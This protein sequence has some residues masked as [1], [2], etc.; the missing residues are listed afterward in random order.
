MS[1]KLFLGGRYFENRLV[2]GIS[3]TGRGV[4]HSPGVLAAA[5]R[6]SG[7]EILNV[8]IRRADLLGPAEQALE[9][10]IEWDRYTLLPNTMGATTAGEAIRTAHLARD[11]TQGDWVK[12][13]ISSDNRYFFPDPVAILEA[14]R[15]LIADGFR[16]MP[17]IQ[18]D[19]ILAQRLEDLGCAA[20]L[21]M[22][23]PIGS[24]QGFRTADNVRIILEKVRIPVLVAAGLAL[25]S[26]AAAALEAG[27]GGVVVNM[28][29]CQA[30][31]P[32][33]MALAFKAGIEAGRHAYLAGPI[34]KLGHAETGLSSQAARDAGDRGDA[35]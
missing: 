26:E 9:D 31:D 14:A 21:P 3:L 6:A 1:D 17:Y 34:P 23:S 28:A 32:V 22:A 30:K 19:P 15:A 35:T 13:E 8:T 24:G 10:L 33:Q 7:A 29:I 5:L 16:V 2:V 4:V 12:L 20:L 11:I 18:A 27:A 25:P